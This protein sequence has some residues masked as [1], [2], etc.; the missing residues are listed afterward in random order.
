MSRIFIIGNGYDVARRGD[1]RYSNFKT[2]LFE[3]YLV[4]TNYIVNNKLNYE[5]ISEKTSL[6]SRLV[7]IC[8]ENN[9]ENKQKEDEFENNELELSAAF[10]YIYMNRIDEKW[11][12]FEEDLAKIPLYSIINEYKNSNESNKINL[13]TSF[14]GSVCK[15]VDILT[16]INISRLFSKWICSLS[17]KKI[18]LNKSAFEN[19]IIKDIQDDDI[20][21]IFNYTNTLEE[22]LGVKNEDS[23]FYHIHG[24]ADNPDSIVVGHNCKDKLTFTN[25]DNQED[26]INEMYASLYKNPE[27]VI[28]DNAELWNKISKLDKVD[29][30]EYGW[31]CSDVDIDYIEK[32]VECLNP[33]GNNKDIHLYLNDFKCSGCYKKSQWIKCGLDK[34]LISLFKEDNDKIIYGNC[35]INWY[36]N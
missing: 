17:N 11:K 36:D 19:D 21:I 35:D 15:E 3:N 1:T 7:K 25:L 14:G 8:F 27:K 32:I 6:D 18:K 13:P 26:Y 9:E 23:R 33:I 10:V 22:I 5:T 24:R 31:S 29:I 28:T 30:Y 4:N 34:S 12:E 20:F 2:W 16:N